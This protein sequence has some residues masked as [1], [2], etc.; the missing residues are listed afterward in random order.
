MQ[1]QPCLVF[2]PFQLD[3]RDERL[4]R[5][6]EVMHL[7]P[8]TLAVLRALVAQ[9][10]QLMTKEALFAAV[11][12][13]TAVSESVLTVAIRE[14]RRALGDPA[15]CPQ[16][17][18][19][20]HGR[21]YRFI[22]P[23]TVVEPLPE[24]PQMARTVRRSQSVALSRSALFVGREGELAQLHQWFAMARQ[25]MRQ[26]GFLTG[27]AGIGKTALV[28]AFVAQVSATEALWVGHGQ[29]LEQY[30]PGEPYLPVLEALG[31]LCRG[32]E[33][34]HCLA[35][36]RQYAPSW[37]VQ[38]PA[39]LPPTDREA[40]QQTAGGAT[41]TRMLRELTE[42]LDR[43]TAERPLVLIF[44]D[45]HWSDVST[46]EWLTYVARRRDWARL[47]ILGTYRPVDAIVRA[48][49]VRTVMTDLKQHQ[50][51]AE[52]PLDYLSPAEVAAYCRQR[53]RATPLPE[54]LACVLYQRTHGHPLFL[55]IIVDEMIRQGLLRE[56]AAGWDVSKAVGTIMVAVPESLRQI[57]EQQLHQVS[58][59]GQGLLEA[60]SIAGIA[61]SAAAVAAVVNQGTEDIEARLAVLAQ[62][63]QFIRSGGLVEW[64]DGTVAAGYTFIHDLYHE[65]LYD[66]VPPSRKI[67]WHL[68]IGARKETGYGARA[69]EIA[70]ELAVHF[71]QGRDPCRAVQ[72]L[73]YAGENALQRS[74]HQEAVTHLT[75]GITLLVQLPDTPDRAQQELRMQT[76]LGTALMV[77]KGFGHSGVERTY[78][79]A[80]ALCQQV[81]DTPGLFPVL[82]GL[83]RYANGRAQHQLA[84][85][86]GE[87]LLAV[88]QQSGD[89]GL[90]LQAHHALWTTAYNTGAFA[91]AYQ[92][93]EHGLALYTSQQHHAQTEIYGGHD[94]GVCGRMHGAR[95]LW[96][97]GYPDQAEQ[98][99]EAALALAQELGHPFTLGYA[100]QGATV[101]HQWQRDVQ[102]TYER[103]TATL[104]LGTAQGA[105]YLV[106]A[107][108]VRLGW[109]VAMRG[110]VEEGVTQISQGLAAWQTIGTSHL[111]AGFLA[112]LAEVYG[113]SG[114]YAEGLAALD[115]ALDIIK[116][117]GGW[118]SEAEF[119][120][121]KGEFLWH[122]GNRPEDVE[123][124][125]HHALTIARRQ[126]AKSRELRAALRLSRFWQQQD[127]QAE[128]YQVLAEVY[129]WFTE[130]FDTADLQ[131]AKALLEELAR[132]G[133]QQSATIQHIKALPTG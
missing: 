112:L 34:P 21:G 63:G 54:E 100:L 105:Q 72:Y 17:I 31:R 14:L 122:A 101:L 44:E 40:L 111:R 107:S 73:Q 36:L 66:R 60:A 83:W 33:G 32:A 131:E 4:W 55:V 119:Y 18:E 37:L 35:L 84:G 104:R 9:A 108:T 96:L 52:L 70:A 98:W 39:L 91:T 43:L 88:A 77:T 116:T 103:A 94:P 93:I 106:A 113:K 7:N 3:L 45:L 75:H 13:E 110:G 22:A 80:R 123:A 128:A 64:P 68:E 115:E 57:I 19:T 124:C 120:G 87:H 50:Q 79:R 81:G 2:G 53:L 118:L 16:F 86:L 58:P 76:A 28:D 129:N 121:L 67:R 82:S 61:F 125:F 74:A 126:Q 114:R 78:A 89:P 23:V 49:P 117:T 47:L 130:G 92:H 69:R 127:K 15:R 20:V 12:P 41:Q 102:R 10:G 8:K 71:V 6:P 95:L 132:G 62:Q 48:H 46:L 85:E 1:E 30:G 38:M 59:E 65:I 42:V 133:T 109:A 27:A 97:L 24:R 11:W 56:E 51:G 99:N 29:C 90:L 26:V 5:G 25:G